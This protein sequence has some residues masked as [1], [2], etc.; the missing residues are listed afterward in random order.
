VA[1]LL[2]HEKVTLDASATFETKLVAVLTIPKYGVP[3]KVER[4]T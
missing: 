3:A 4:T 2:G 1:T